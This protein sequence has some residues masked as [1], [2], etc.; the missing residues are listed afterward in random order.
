MNVVNTVNVIL[1]IINYY[2]T[3]V[4]IA[5]NVRIIK[6]ACHTLGILYLGLFMCILT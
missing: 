2:Y 6:T 3:V 5:L 4:N 1:Y